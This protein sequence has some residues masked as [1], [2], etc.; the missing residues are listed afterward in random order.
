M[1]NVIADQ[2]RRSRDA[3]RFW[4]END[5]FSDDELAAIKATSMRDLLDVTS[6]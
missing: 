3:D 2:L 5:Q 4:Y 6:T 1:Q